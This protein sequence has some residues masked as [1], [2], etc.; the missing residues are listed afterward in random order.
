MLHLVADRYFVYVCISIVPTFFVL[1]HV[2]FYVK[3]RTM[4]VRTFILAC[5]FPCPIML[6]HHVLKLW[7]KWFAKGL[8]GNETS[9]ITKIPA[10]ERSIGITSE[11]S[12]IR[13]TG[14]GIPNGDSSEK[15]QKSVKDKSKLVQ[16][17]IETEMEL[18]T[19]QEALNEIDAGSIDSSEKNEHTEYTEDATLRTSSP[20]TFVTQTPTEE[21]YKAILVESSTKVKS[22]RA[23]DDVEVLSNEYGHLKDN[24]EGNI[25]E[26]EAKEQKNDINW[27]RTETSE[28][29]SYEE[30]VV[31]SLL[32]TLQGSQFVWN[33]IHL[34]RGSQNLQGKS[35]SLQDILNWSCN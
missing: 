28:V 35:G 6:W 25:A 16:V 20:K 32:K 17:L 3:D 1:S 15:L 31:E 14:S 8:K 22:K 27:K 9:M 10:S 24:C 5:L 34:V 7:N 4:S 23:D 19:L 33:E 21:K 18:N 29:I 11:I 30:E 13:A 12:E 26:V 2:P